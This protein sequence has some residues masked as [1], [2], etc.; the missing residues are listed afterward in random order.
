MIKRGTKIVHNKIRCK[1]CGE[2]IES[3]SRHDFV[4][5][6]CFRDSGGSKG[7][8]VDGG[9]DYI[10]W[11]GNREDFEDLCETRPFTD[12]EVDEYNRRQLQIKKDFD[13]KVELME[14]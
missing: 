14:K 3:M 10:R 7:C 2:T 6:K 9:H 1:L 12:E 13:W 5:C 11:G 4:P 8:F